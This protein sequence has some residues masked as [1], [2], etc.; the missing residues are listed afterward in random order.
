ML[1]FLAVN[2]QNEPICPRSHRAVLLSLKWLVLSPLILIIDGWFWVIA[3][4]IAA[5]SLLLYASSSFFAS[6]SSCRRFRSALKFCSATRNLPAILNRKN[7]PV[8]RDHDPPAQG[9]ANFHTTHWT[10]V[11]SAAQSREPGATSALSELFR[12]YWYPLYIFARRCGHS[13]HDAQDFTQGFFVRLIERKTLIRANPL[14]G[15]FR[16]FLLTSFKNYLCAEAERTHPQER[17]SL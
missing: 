6:V 3:D 15:K 2:K 16:S 11:L 14:R 5:A 7:P 4:T 10:V 1:S 17:R 13:P 9:T 8:K 12:L